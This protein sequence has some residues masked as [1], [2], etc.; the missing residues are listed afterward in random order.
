MKK[1]E[2]S[3]MVTIVLSIF[4]FIGF[5][6]GMV[7]FFVWKTDQI[8]AQIIGVL[9][10]T[11]VSA[12]V[13]MLLLTAQTKSEE[14]HEIR[15]K[16]LD[17]KTKA[18]LTILDSLEKIISDGKVDTIK[19]NKLNEKK[20]EFSQLLFEITRLSSFVEVEQKNKKKDKD[21][22]KESVKNAEKNDMAVLIGAV[23]DILNATAT[24]SDEE[25]FNNKSFWNGELK[26]KKT[27]DEIQRT[28]YTK[29]AQS[30][31]KINWFATENIASVK[32]DLKLEDLVKNSELFR[33]T[34][35]QKAENLPE[36]AL[37]FRKTC[38][39]KCLKE[40]EQQLKAKFGKTEREGNAGDDYYWGRW[41]DK[42]TTEETIVDWLLEKP[43][44]NEIGYK[45]DFADGYSVEFC[46][47]G[48]AKTFGIYVCAS[49]DMLEKAEAKRDA[50]KDKFNN[51]WWIPDRFAETGWIVGRCYSGDYNGVNLFFDFR[52]GNN[53]SKAEYEVAYQKFKENAIQGIISGRDDSIEKTV[54]QLKKMIEG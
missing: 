2:T 13:T 27:P 18:Y 4:A 30:L 17:Q 43:R 16:I 47:Y 25:I 46:I 41:K 29:L 21:N 44:R 20:D 12:L 28:Y 50:I 34:E 33:D 10:G 19:D 37:D 9:F 15:G 52:N 8:P 24:S 5:V 40:M 53:L 7:W 48:D 32:N 42:D 54:E 51:G 23:S 36:E 38:L 26:D 31:E 45:V 22:K 11:L 3:T 6:F 49:K 35:K 39:V 14:E 1:R